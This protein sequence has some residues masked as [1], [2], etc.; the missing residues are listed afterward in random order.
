MKKIDDELLYKWNKILKKQ[1]LG[2]ARPGIPSDK[3]AKDQAKSKRKGIPKWA[4]GSLK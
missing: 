4:K 1:G 3:A 2:A